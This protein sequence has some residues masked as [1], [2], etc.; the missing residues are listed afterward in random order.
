[1]DFGFP[2]FSKAGAWTKTKPIGNFY[3]G[4]SRSMEEIAAVAGGL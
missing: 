2:F 1:M 3:V 4:C